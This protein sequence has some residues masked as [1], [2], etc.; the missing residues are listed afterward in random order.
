MQKYFPNQF[1][2]NDAS[3]NA[4]P[5]FQAIKYFFV[6]IWAG[7]GGGGGKTNLKLNIK[8][9]FCWKFST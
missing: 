9:E 6:V 3:T 4:A 2:C 1:H 5:F 8:A 7:G